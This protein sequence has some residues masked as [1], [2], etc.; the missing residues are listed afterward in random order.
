MHKILNTQ[1]KVGCEFFRE[2]RISSP[3]ARLVNLACYP[4]GSDSSIK[5]FCPHNSL[6]DDGS[7]AC[8]TRSPNVIQ[9]QLSES[10]G[11]ILAQ[12]HAAIN[13]GVILEFTSFSHQ[14]FQR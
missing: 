4:D 8:E 14:F 1:L 2:L 11:V 6:R 7:V 5:I 9:R 13:V 10:L 12:Y 3:H